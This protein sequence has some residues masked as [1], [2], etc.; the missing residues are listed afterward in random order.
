VQGASLFHVY[1]RHWLAELSAARGRDVDLFS[2]PDDVIGELAKR[3][4][5]HVWLTGVW[6]TGEQS[7]RIARTH[8]G[9]RAEYDVALP[10]WTHSDVWGS[11]YS[12][13]TYHVADAYGGDAGLAAFRRK[14]AD[15]GIGLLLDF[16]P[17]HIGIDHPWVREQPQRCVRAPSTAAA[18]DATLMDTVHGPMH[19]F[20]GK[21]PYFPGWTDTIQLD[22]RRQSTREA[23]I[24]VLLGLA[25]MCDGVRCDM[26]M[27]CLRDVFARTWAHAAP[28]PDED[29]AHGEFWA[30]AAERVRAEHPQFRL[31][32]EAYWGTGPALI[33]N[34]FDA[35]YDKDI[36]DHL[37]HHDLNALRGHVNHAD[38]AHHVRFLENHDEPRA[39]VAFPDVNH[40]RACLLLS[41]VLPGAWMEHHGQRDGARVFA[42][43]Q[44]AKRQHETVD[45]AS[46]DLHRRVDTAMAALGVAGGMQRVDAQPA[47][48]GNHSHHQL[49]VFLQDGTRAGQRPA[50][51]VINLAGQRAQGYLPLSFCGDGAWHLHDLLGHERWQRDGH[52]LRTRGL[53]VDVDAF[54]SQLFSL[55]P[56]PD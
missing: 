20:H 32:A 29:V 43:I 55:Q 53:Y 3:G 52:D 54:A 50:L 41:R 38:H 56:S 33:A 30:A 17:N 31:V 42:R 16:V 49:F 28:P 25:R 46:V 27:L 47:W 8:A 35:I 5:T 1:V 13:A 51:C 10:G 19:L 21:D 26:A 4:H 6:P 11:P 22:H 24:G 36:Y 9:L 45:T 7:K 15:A 2:I 34:G 12:V 23:M 18:A 48:D 40:R 37:R 14:L 39:R 44:L